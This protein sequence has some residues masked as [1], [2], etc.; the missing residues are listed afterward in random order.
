MHLVKFHQF[1]QAIA[2]QDFLYAQFSCN[3]TISIS[4]AKQLLSNTFFLHSF[5]AM[6]S[7]P[8]VLPSDCWATLSL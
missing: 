8:S 2:E 3:A 4:T 6:P 7:I 5:P 1:S